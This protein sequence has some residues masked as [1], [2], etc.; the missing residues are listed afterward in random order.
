MWYKLGAVVKKVSWRRSDPLAP[1][2]MQTW[3]G[4]PGWD[5]GAVGEYPAWRASPGFVRRD[6]PL[7]ILV[8]SQVRE[9]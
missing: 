8:E 3:Q 6:Q 1:A 5:A 7:E 2:R 9:A 4:V